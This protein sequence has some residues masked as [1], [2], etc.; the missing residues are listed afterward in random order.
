MSEAP[1]RIW[2]DGQD[3]WANPTFKDNKTEYVRAD[4]LHEIF[5]RYSKAE[6][7]RI[8]ELEAKLASTE[9]DLAATIKMLQASRRHNEHLEAKLESALK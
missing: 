7:A 5:L 1:E 3:Y 9:S 4:I 6:T 8:E 2:V